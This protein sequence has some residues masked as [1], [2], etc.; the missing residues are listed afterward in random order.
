M[1]I[2]SKNYIP[3]TESGILK[4]YRFIVEILNFQSLTIAH[5]HATNHYPSLSTY[6]DHYL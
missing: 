2:I 6:P 4:S 3:L 1:K 5:T